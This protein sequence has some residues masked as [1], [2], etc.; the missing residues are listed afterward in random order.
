[1][2]KIMKIKPLDNRV[3][4]RPIE[5]Q[6]ISPGGIIIPEAAKEKS[7]RGSV[8]AVGPGKLADDG[9]ITA[10]SVKP[11]DKVIYSTYA[12]TEIKKDGE[13][14]LLIREDDILALIKE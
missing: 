1:M 11:G 10:V 4:L 8:V 14:Y 3:L 7:I 13:K 2:E 5:A 12:G 9:T 6:E